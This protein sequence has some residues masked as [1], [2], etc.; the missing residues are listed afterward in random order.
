MACSCLAL[1]LAAHAQDPAE[2]KVAFLRERVSVKTNTG[3]SGF[4]PGTRVAIVARRGDVVIVRAADQQF[5]VSADQLITDSEAARSLSERDA[6]AQQALQV[7]V[8]QREALKQ[9]A[10]R[11]QEGELRKR[12][13][14]EAPE[15]KEALESRLRNID[16]QSERLRIELDRI[17]FEQK[18]LPPPNSSRFGTIRSS[19]NS[20][21]LAQRE[22]EIERKIHN[23]TEQERLLRLE[24]E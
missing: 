5:Q 13:A 1:A 23:L 21:A 18:G 3:I 16:K 20:F 15:R 12:Q 19:P 22:K 14:A 4:A 17:H 8:R 6:A 2:I 10:A 7:R 9:Q 24:S 11:S